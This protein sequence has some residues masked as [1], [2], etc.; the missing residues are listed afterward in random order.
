MNGVNLGQLGLNERD[1]GNFNS[2][3]H[4]I[5][6]YLG[7]VD[8]TAALELVR[9]L[10]HI[11]TL[12][13]NEQEEILRER[14]SSLSTDDRVHFAKVRLVSNLVETATTVMDNMQGQNDPASN[15]F[16]LPSVIALAQEAGYNSR[17]M[18]SFLNTV[19]I[20]K[21]ITPHPTE[22]LNKEGR[23]L[24]RELM[25]ASEMEPAQR[26]EHINKIAAQM[27]QTDIAPTRKATMQEETQDALEQSVIHRSGIR[28]L[29]RDMSAAIAQ[30]YAED[31]PNA[32]DLLSPR[33]RIDMALRIWHAGDA[34]G[35]PN[36]DRWSLMTTMVMLAKESVRDH[37]DDF[38]KAIALELGLGEK[39]GIPLE[40]L[41]DHV[42]SMD[43]SRNEKD[44]LR[45]NIKKL[46]TSFR[47]LE[48]LEQNCLLPDAEKPDYEALKS[49]FAQ[50]P[51]GSTQSR[52]MCR[53]LNFL[54]SKFNNPQA[55]EI[56]QES[57]F[58][59]RMH[60]YS[61]A[62]IETR[63]NG[64]VYDKIMDNLFSNQEFLNKIDVPLNGQQSITAHGGFSKLDAEVQ[65]SMMDRA[66]HSL[67]PK[68]LQSYLFNTNRDSRAEDDPFPP[69]THEFLQRFR[70]MADHPNMFGMALIAEAKDMS[71]EYQQFFAESFGVKNIINT[72]LPEE[73]ETLESL[74][75]AFVSYNS[76]GGKRNIQQR[77]A[78][79]WFRKERE[80]FH[81]LIIPCSDSTKQLGVFGKFQLREAIC[82]VIDW[83]FQNDKIVLTKE[84][85]G[86][87]IGRGGGTGKTFYRYIMQNLKRNVDTQVLPLN[88]HDKADYAILEHAS[89]MSNT[90]QGRFFRILSAT[91]QQVAGDLASNIGEMLGCRMELEGLV[92]DATFIAPYDDFS[93]NLN[94]AV[95][96]AHREML[97]YRG[98][99]NIKND[100]GSYVLDN[101]ADIVSNMDVAGAAN[102]GARPD[103]K[104]KKS[105]EF[106]KQ[107]AIGS[108]IIL[109]HERTMY[110]SN[111][112]NGEGL[113][114]MYREFANGNLDQ[115]DLDDL[116]NSPFW[117]DH[118]QTVF[119]SLAQADITHG[120]R[121]LGMT[122]WTHD[123]MMQTAASVNMSFTNV[124]GKYVP[125]MTFD[126]QNG[127]ISKEQAFHAFVY[128]DQFKSIV[129][130]ETLLNTGAKALPNPED[131]Y[132]IEGAKYN[133][134]LAKMEIGESTLE[135]WEMAAHMRN[136]ANKQHPERILSDLTQEA[137]Q[138]GEKVA[139][140]YLRLV[141]S[142]QRS[143]TAQHA[144]IYLDQSPAFGHIRKAVWDSSILKPKSAT[145]RHFTPVAEL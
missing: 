49:E 85:N 131:L 133:G 121:R 73:K 68:D 88:R 139:P 92:K 90:V 138:S 98:W 21:S 103:S 38:T 27:L 10:R 62:K 47:A 19:R 126:D 14:I 89:F 51:L 141:S 65:R 142:V 39:Q 101:Y 63:H 40:E 129:L 127:K 41:F 87:A 119:M 1:N 122:D 18:E 132:A 97:R 75:E 17:D 110:D 42:E 112:M 25:K 116:M 6:Q 143:T 16:H 96:G 46:A 128:A 105:K 102:S 84:G 52:E 29:Y 95:D 94:A 83:A 45:S 13:Y 114:M 80:N 44:R 120:A 55:R 28:S 37:L 78:S 79:A 108:N 77:M 70:L 137:I 5:D 111:L 76:N 125:D 2:N 140:D 66:R 3:N 69:Q 22:H 56:L 24:Y 35:K 4:Y 57:L 118:L 124:N 36:S 9:D 23:D 91:P 136:A 134:T 61:S 145:I 30:T 43:N 20:W 11:E 60:G 117:S 115:S 48:R 81:G 50:L 71:S 31:G 86:G 130:T 67:I 74:T 12:P 15:G 64:D 135:R 8:A 113:E 82:E 58:L 33:V 34:D 59:L 144:P 106:L 93:P 72:P 107:R 53:D 100:D 7:S 32:P 109:D 104:S 26:L 54:H 123:D 99:R